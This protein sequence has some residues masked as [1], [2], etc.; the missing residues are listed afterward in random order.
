MIRLRHIAVL[1][2]ASVATLAAATALPARAAAAPIRP[3][4]VTGPLVAT[5][6]PPDLAEC[7]KRFHISC[8]RPQHLQQAYDLPGL[9]AQGL[10]GTGRTIVIIDAYGSPTIHKDLKSFDQAFGLPDPPKFKVIKLGRIPAYD[11][12]SRSRRSWARETSLDV[13]W[14]H[15]MAPGAGI[16]LL[17]VGPARGLSTIGQLEPLIRAVHYSLD[18]HLGDVISLSFGVGEPAFQRKRTCGRCTT[19]SPWQSSAG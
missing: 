6:T 13:Q 12:E 19:S 16:V 11:P 2:V 1:A 10:N 7:R 15:A 4:L 5:V 8:Y 18:H 14:A 9:Y 17:E 3:P